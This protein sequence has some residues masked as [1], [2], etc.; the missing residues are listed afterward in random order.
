MYHIIS[1]KAF[2][3]LNLHKRNSL[4]KDQY[5]F[6]IS[7]KE[8][9]KSWLEILKQDTQAKLGMW[10]Y[11]GK[12]VEAYAIQEFIENAQKELDLIKGRVEEA[13]AIYEQIQA[14]KKLANEDK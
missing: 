11:R 8:E 7:S 5:E 4:T 12:E 9:I 3:D 14:S 13:K 2:E 10:Y 6:L 1:K